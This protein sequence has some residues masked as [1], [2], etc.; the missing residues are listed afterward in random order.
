MVNALTIIMLLVPNLLESKIE[1]LDDISDQIIAEKHCLRLYSQYMKP[2]DNSI[3]IACEYFGLE[4]EKRRIRECSLNTNCTTR[5]IIWKYQK[6]LVDHYNSGL[7]HAYMSLINHGYNSQNEKLIEHLLE[8][9]KPINSDKFFSQKFKLKINEKVNFLLREKYFSEIEFLL[10][11]KASVFEDGLRNN[12]VSD[13]V[14]SSANFIKNRM[15][16]NFNKIKRLNEFLPKNEIFSNALKVLKRK[17]YGNARLVNQASCYR[18]NVNKRR[19]L[20]EL[21][22]L[23]G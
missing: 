11:H 21:K 9:Q 10:D 23:N 18:K 22:N 5:L 17:F 16:D 7:E 3:K 14:Y 13:D 12:I 4:L 19:C 15:D 2:N 1:N 6:V 20:K 8:T